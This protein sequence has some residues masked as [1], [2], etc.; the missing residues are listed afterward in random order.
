ML[1]LLLYEDEARH[2]MLTD[3]LELHFEVTALEAVGK[4]SNKAKLNS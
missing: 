1:I 4:Q 3:V 2:Y